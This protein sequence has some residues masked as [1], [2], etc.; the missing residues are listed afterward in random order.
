MDST[1]RVMS[2]QHSPIA[3]I[4]AVGDDIA[5]S[6]RDEG[7]P[8]SVESWQ[9]DNGIDAASDSIATTA[10]LAAFNYFL[11]TTLYRAYQ[12][13]GL[14]LS[15]LDVETAH[16]QLQAAYERTNDEAFHENPLDVVVGDIDQQ[17][18]KPLLTNCELIEAADSPTNLIGDIFERLVGQSVRRKHGQFH[19]PQFIAE[20]MA[21]WAVRKNDD[22]VLD[23]G[24]G[25]GVLTAA[26]YRAKQNLPG[27]VAVDEMWGVDINRIAVVMASTALKLENGTG[28]PNLFSQDYMDTVARGHIGQLN[29]DAKVHIP[30]VDAIVSNPPY[31]R[32]E[33]LDHHRERYNDIVDHVADV[34]VSGR[35]PLF[36]YFLFHSAQFLK[37]DGRVA[38]ITPSQFVDT[39]YG[40]TL[41]EFLT[42]RFTVHAFIFIDFD[43]GVFSGTDVMPCIT[44]LENGTPSDD[45]ETVFVRVDEWP[46]D[47]AVLK[48]AI[49]DAQ[50]GPTGFG[51]VSRHTQ[52][53]LDATENWR[54][55][56][57][58]NVVDEIE[59]LTTFRKVATIKRGIAT[60]K[61]DY[62]CLTQ[63]D[64]D[65][66]DLDA[67]FLVK[68]IRRSDGHRK[69]EITPADWERWR[70]AG[71]T[72]WLLYCYEDDEPIDSIEND[73]LN[74]YLE[75]GR[76]R[77]AD[78]SYLARNR[79][80][81]F[82]VDERPPPDIV[83]TYM[84]K[85]GFRFMRNRAG[86][87]TLNNFHN[88]SLPNF[89]SDEIDALLAYLNSN[90]AD[91]ITKRSGRRY[92]RGLHK[93]E[94]DELKDVLVLD[95][96]ELLN[97]DV[98]RLAQ[99]YRNVC[100]EAGDGANNVAAARAALN[101]TVHEVLGLCAE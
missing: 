99:A 51:Y 35:M 58:S 26:M 28:T 75:H 62:F 32:S 49:C 72:V 45:H 78:T 74:A 101:R 31:S 95:P 4:K 92:A 6:L 59:G 69:L 77:E 83:A 25:A 73:S 93:I 63:H 16:T 88:I 7:L 57:E 17:I 14:R 91:E 76:E 42:D 60:G 13:D 85:D 90:V 47:A 8:A 54:Q 3:L 87:R 36:A 55:Y 18:L 89:D 52:A 66:W 9:E 10:D 29:Q 43:V 50:T 64:V 2:Q 23:P 27:D 79:S 41:R 82:V 46:S 71:K 44:L 20:F 38:V 37:P 81:W 40:R 19:T 67:R 68:I 97:D 65:E 100:S 34:S 12:D 96:R 21:S 53:S 98:Q 15:E 30:A 24:V 70:D 33:V 56:T 22:V 86:I 11:K 5:D 48:T 84:S 39:V 94:P 1:G 80:P 61:N